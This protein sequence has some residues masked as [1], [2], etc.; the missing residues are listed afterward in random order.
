MS[1]SHAAQDNPRLLELYQADQ[2]ERSRVYDSTEEVKQLE[3]RD[4]MRRSLVREMIPKGDIR[5]ADD[6]YRAAVVLQHGDSPK[7]FLAA[8]RLAV[9]AAI[10]GH[11]G[12]RWLAAASLDRFLM[13]LGQP[14]VYGTQFEHV[15]E[16]NKYALK[17]PLDD[18]GVLP[19]EK[20]F[21]NVPPVV[22]RLSQLNAKIKPKR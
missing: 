12:G 18:Q 7:D 11:T 5:T 13:S 2:T 8:H 9:M 21:F 17:L 4:A 6:L 1:P 20:K 16:E 19:N 10:G 14:Q 22:E 15:R 3:H